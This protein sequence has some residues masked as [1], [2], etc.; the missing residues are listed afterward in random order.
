MSDDQHDEPR[1]SFT[2]R[3]LHRIGKACAGA[4][5]R[6]WD[7]ARGLASIPIDGIQFGVAAIRGDKEEMASEARQIGNK[8][9]SVV[10]AVDLLAPKI[11]SNTMWAGLRFASVGIREGAQTAQ[12]EHS[13][14]KGIGGGLAGG[15][16]AVLDKT[17]IVP[18]IDP[19]SKAQAAL[20]TKHLVDPPKL[21]D[22]SA[23]SHPPPNASADKQA[24]K[25]G[26]FGVEA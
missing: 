23:P 6:V 7:A 13:I 11:V 22:P 17:N 3:I 24:P 21:V 18:E 5:E 4:I 25:R 10:S 19:K 2:S 14:T 1:P 8:S 26:G 15:I 9:I 12:E 16:E 20:V